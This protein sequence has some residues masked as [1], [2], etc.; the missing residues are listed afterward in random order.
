VRFGQLAFSL[1]TSETTL[2][3]PKMSSMSAGFREV[4]EK[5]SCRITRFEKGTSFQ[6]CEETTGSKRSYSVTGV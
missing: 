4:A 2:F 1:K 5:L 6:I 3:V